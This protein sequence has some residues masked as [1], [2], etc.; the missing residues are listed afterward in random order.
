M[1][2]FVFKLRGLGADPTI[3]LA[4][5]LG[6]NATIRALNRLRLVVGGVP[7]TNEQLLTRV[8]TRFFEEFLLAD[9][10]AR[11]DPALATAASG[12]TKEVSVPVPDVT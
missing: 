8:W 1:A 5:P 2:N 7:E 3:G 9:Y 10:L 12:V 4:F 6:D 11:K